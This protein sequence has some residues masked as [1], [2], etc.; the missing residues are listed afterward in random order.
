VDVVGRE[1]ELAALDA[2]LALRGQC[3]ASLVLAGEAGIGKSTIVRAAVARAEAAGLRVLQARPAEGEAEL[4]YAGLADL[5]TPFDLAR[6]GELARP[7][8]EAL[9]A[10]TARE[11]SSA[12]VDAH[13]LSRG[14]LE[15]LRLEAASGDLLVVIDDVQWL[16]RPTAGALQFAFRRIGTVPL[17]VLVAARSDAAV[18]TPPFGLDQWDDVRVTSVGGLTATELGAL[19]RQ[20]LGVQLSRPRLEELERHS[21]G[22]PLFA[23]ELARSSAEGAAQPMT[24]AR[25]LQQ[26]ILGLEPPARDAVGAA[27]AA[28]RPTVDLLLGAGVSRAGLETAVAGGM[29]ELRGDRLRFTHPLLASAAYESLLP[30][31]RRRIHARLAEASSDAVER[32]HHVARSAARPDE[33]AAKAL[34]QAADEAAARGDHAGAAAFLL[35]AAELS[36]DSVQR[37]LRA[38]AELQLAGDVEAAAARAEALVRRIPPGA[39]RAEARYRFVYCSIGSTTSF[40]DAL[41]Q[42]DAAL[43]EADD[44]VIQA[45][46]HLGMA[47]MML[48]TCQLQDSLGHARR[49]LELAERAGASALAVEALGKIGFG[50]SMLGHGVTPAMRRAAELWDGTVGTSVPPRTTLAVACTAALAFDEAEDLLEQEVAFASERGL[51]QLEV[52]ARLHL[53]EAQLRAG[54]WSD[55]LRNGRLAVE[56][57]RQASEVEAVGGASYGLAMTLAL[58]GVHDEARAVAAEAL[59]SAEASHDSW[60]VILHRAVLG[61]V[62]LTEGDPALAAEL[63]E[64]AWA[65]MID[66]RLGDLSMFPVAQTLGEALVDVGRVD[67]ALG[68]AAALRACR[69]GNAWC[70]AMAARLEGLVASARRDHA[71]ARASFAAAFEAHADFAEPFEHARTLL[72]L[73]R[74]ERSARSWGA[75]RAAFTD[76]LERFDALGAARW[77]EKAAADLARLPG[78]RP[79]DGTALT[80]REREV[81]ELAATG[82]ANKEIASRLYLSVSTVETNLSRAYAK[83]GVRSRTELAARLP[84]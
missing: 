46:I 71:W 78:R 17:G 26:R 58:I 49:A 84:R 80:L 73:G 62:A 9:A 32:G 31:V 7:Q 38:A 35:R 19:V 2:F 59:A 64:P 16:D 37:E 28:L 20:R 67:D 33:H 48:V 41:A 52:I 55:A 39:D 21:G 12:A 30:D 45:E 13:A 47:E 83:L 5:L 24:L 72:L 77:S 76:A 65:L 36:A 56:H 29:L 51:E 81:A 10:A 40:D 69:A 8:R 82:L 27:A 50:E 57:A 22:N 42:L 61:Q 11:G 60:F 66:R 3:P 53:A 70:R 6:L 43:A 75:A 68:V 1:P 14:V 15:L 4:P 54:R 23:L 63:L 18:P 34:D 79:A 74:V 25:A 44:E